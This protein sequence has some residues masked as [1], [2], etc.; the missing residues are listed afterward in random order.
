M[1]MSA[2]YDEH[3]TV[4]PSP[5]FHCNHFIHMEKGGLCMECAN[6][7]VVEPSGPLTL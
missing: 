7:S 6:G 2:E 4:S 1:G 3:P 5:L